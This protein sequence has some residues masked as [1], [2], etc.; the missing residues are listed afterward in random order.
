MASRRN[1]KKDIDYLTYEVIADCYTYMHLYPENNRDKVMK[2]INETVEMRNDLVARTNHPDAKDDAKKVKA[3]Y[4]SIRKELLE[5][6]DVSFQ[7]LSK[8][9]K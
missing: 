6:I 2:I 3:Y 7:N 9:V 1:L 4:Q 8:L 5:K